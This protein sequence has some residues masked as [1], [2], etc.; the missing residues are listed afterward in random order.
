MLSWDDFRIMK[1]IADRGSLTEAAKILRIN[2]STVFRKLGQIE[3]RLDARLFKRSRSG[4][5]LTPRGEEMVRLA[6]R[7]E[8]D[9]AALDL[10]AGEGQRRRGQ[11]ENHRNARDDKLFALWHNRI[12]ADVCHLKAYRSRKI[13]HHPRVVVAHVLLRRLISEPARSQM[14][15]GVHGECC[16]GM[17]FAS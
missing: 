11:R 3:H 9:V 10:P 16:R 4:Y 5:T 14:Q 1:A 8:Q 7:M 13:I 6:E 17:I 15:P 2:Q 12:R